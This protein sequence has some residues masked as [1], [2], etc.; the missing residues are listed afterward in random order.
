M[1]PIVRIDTLLFLQLLGYRN[2]LIAAAVRA[3]DCNS[4]EGDHYL[5]VGHPWAPPS[6]ATT[7][8]YPFF[9]FPFLFGFFWFLFGFFVGYVRRLF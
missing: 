1:K 3:L 2:I 6:R 7:S 8:L 9:F 4:K 5:L